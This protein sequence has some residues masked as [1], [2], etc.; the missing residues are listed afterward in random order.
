MRTTQRSGVA[1]ATSEE[2]CG[3]TAVQALLLAM[4][5][6]FVPPP[7]LDS[8]SGERRWGG[9]GGGGVALCPLANLAAPLSHMAFPRH[10]PRTR[11]RH[12]HGTSSRCCRAKTPPPPPQPGQ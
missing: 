6:L 11:P 12:L 9:G 4:E 10:V 8:A 3:C 5:A 2:D 1:Q 7:P